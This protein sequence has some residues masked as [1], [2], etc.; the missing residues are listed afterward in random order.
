MEYDGYILCEGKPGERQ[1]KIVERLH[2][3]DIIST[4][5]V[6]EDYLYTIGLYH[7]IFHMLDI[8]GLHDIF[9]RKEPT[10]E[11]LTREFLSSLIYIVNPNTASTV[12]TMKFQ[13]FNVE[14]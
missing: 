7:S 2:W 11:R 1:Q 5:Y 12:S 10:F 8:L 9:A 6:D 3:R 4:R 14:Y 13:M